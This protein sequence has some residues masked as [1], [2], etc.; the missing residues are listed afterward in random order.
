MALRTAWGAGFIGGGC[1]DIEDEALRGSAGLA[2]LF[3]LVAGPCA[4][5]FDDV[6]WAVWACW[7]PWRPP[8]GVGGFRGWFGALGRFQAVD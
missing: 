6:P 2:C 7:R 3:G 5:S 8:P 4:T 1:F